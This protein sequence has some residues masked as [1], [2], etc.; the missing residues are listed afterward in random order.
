MESPDVLKEQI[1][2]LAAADCAYVDAAAEV[3]N[4]EVGRD[5][6]GDLEALIDLY[7]MH[8]ESL[9][10]ARLALTLKQQS[11]LMKTMAVYAREFVS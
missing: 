8:E 3:L 5:N 4:T 1:S 7:E 9:R 6:M 2:R 10:Q 11:C